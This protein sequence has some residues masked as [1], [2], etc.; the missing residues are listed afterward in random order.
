MKTLN[1]QKAIIDALKD[2]PQ[3]KL[4]EVA[5]FISSIRQKNFSKK[6]DSQN[7]IYKYVSELSDNETKHLEEEF[8]DY[9]KLY[10]RE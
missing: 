4:K 5:D 1:F 3:E 7:S 9:K 10:P 6:P 2:L 8:V